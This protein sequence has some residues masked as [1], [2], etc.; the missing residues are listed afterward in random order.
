VEFEVVVVTYGR[1]ETLL[2]NYATLRALYPD[3]PV[4][5]GVQGPVSN[6]VREAAAADPLLRVEHREQPHITATLNQCIRSSQAQVAVML[7][8]DAGPC[9]GWLEGFRAAFAAHPE[10]AY[11]MGREIR[12]RGHGLAGVLARG[13]L[14]A[15]C[16]PFVPAGALSGGRL[17]GRI[18]GAGFLLGNFDLPGVC[19]INAPR[20][21]NLA[22]RRAAFLDLGGFSENFTGNQWGFEADFGLRAQHAGLDGIFWGAAMA[23]HDQEPKGGTRTVRTWGDLRHAVHNHAQLNRLLG[24]W[25]WIGAVPRLVRA[26]WKSR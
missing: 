9:P 10:A 16:R 14:E 24:P 4:C 15:L 18:N 8:D 11:V 20:G 26:A 6:R 25:A 22:V 23:V 13:V 12:T 5:W 21:C 3:L 1:D 7:D 19:R 17:I 2:K